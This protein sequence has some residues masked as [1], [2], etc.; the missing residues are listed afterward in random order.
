MKRTVAFRVLVNQDWHVDFL[1]WS[2]SAVASGRPCAHGI[3][4]PVRGCSTRPVQYRMSPPSFCLWGPLLTHL[5]L[6]ERLQVR[7]RCLMRRRERR[8]ISYRWCL[9]K[10]NSVLTTIQCGIKFAQLLH[11]TGF[12]HLLRKP[13]G[14]LFM[15]WCAILMYYKDRSL[16]RY[17]VIKAWLG[18][19]TVLTSR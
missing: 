10:A 16:R 3:P 11:H 4:P 5:L 6:N 13:R 1:H 19:G 8:P 14:S 18:E 12:I 17:H 9:A 7:I 2:A 15:G